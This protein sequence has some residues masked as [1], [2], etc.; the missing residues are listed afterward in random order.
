[1]NS[2]VKRSSSPM[3]RFK[4]QF[5]N[6]GSS[7]KLSKPREG[8]AMA[9]W[10][11]YLSSE[12][13]SPSTSYSWKQK[14]LE[15]QPSSGNSQKST[16]LDLVVQ[17]SKVADGLLNRMY[18]LN[19][20]LENPDVVSH[21]FSDP[22]WKAGILPN[23][24][25]ICTLVSKK[26][27]EH[28]SKLQLERVDKVA[29]DSISQN[30]EV[31]LQ[32]LEPWVMFLIDLMEFREQSLRLILDLSST[33]ITLLPHQNSLIL[34][35][36]MDLF[37]SFARVNLFSNKIPRK[38]FIQVYNLLHGLS[39]GGRDFEYYNRVVQ[40]INSYDPPIK[41]LQEDL[42]FV[43]P[44]IGE[45]LE[46][47]GPS[48]FL[49]TDTKKLRNEGFLSPFHP[50]YPDILTNSAHP[51][52]AQDLANVTSYREWVLLGY[53]VC[54]DELLR[55]T[56]IDI[57]M[58]ALKESMVLT[59]YRDEYLLLH[60]EYQLHVLPRILESKR[61]AKSGRTKQKEADLE[62]NVAKQVEKMICEVHEE[63]VISCNAIH[64]ERRVLLKQEIGRMVLFFADQPSLLAP[65]IQMVFSAL[66]FAQSEIIWFFQHLSASALGSKGTRLMPA[67]IDAA[68]PTIGFLLH[69]MDRL[70]SLVRKY[71]SAIRGY[72]LS[73]LSSCAGRMRFLLG[74]PGMVA[75]DLDAPLK[76]LFQQV[77]LCLDN[78]RKPQGDNISSLECDLSDL[79]RHWISILMIVTS[80]RSSINIRHLEKATASTGKEGLLSEGNFAYNWSRCV[81]EL[82]SQ[83]LKYG[84]LAKLYFY[85][86]HL[87]LVFKNTMFGP[88]GHPQH[89]VAWLGVAANF[90]CCASSTAPE[91]V[92]KIGRDSVSYVESLIESIMGGL[93]GLINILDAE[94]GFGSLDSQLSPEQVGIQIM[95]ETKTSISSSRSGK[96]FSGFLVPGLE[97]YPGNGK[98]LKTLEAAMQRLTDLCSVLNDMEPVC[99]LNHVFVLRE[100]MRD[101][102]LGNFRK[103][104]HSILKKDNGLQRPSV[105]ESLLRRHISI[106]HLAEQHISM[107]LTTGIREALLSEAYL[108][109]V[110]FLQTFEK[111]T[112]SQA[113]SAIEI[114]SNWYIDQIVKDVSGADVVFSPRHNCF[115]S[116][117]RTGGNSAENFT[118]T[119]ELKALFRIFGRYGFDKLDRAMREHMAALLN[120]IESTLLSNSEVL[121]AFEKER[122]LRQIVELESVVGFF[123]QAGRTIAFHRI[124]A[125]SAGAVFRENAPLI[126]SLLSSLKDNL[127]DEIPD[128]DPAKRLRN[129][130]K[131]CG[132][133]G[134]LDAEWVTSIMLERGSFD[135]GSWI[136]L[137]RLC[138]SFVVSSIWNTTHYDVH[139]GGFNTNL[140][141]LARSI[142]A[143]IAASEFV[144]SEKSELLKQSLSNGHGIEMH[145]GILTRL[146]VIENIKSSMQVYV[147]YSAGLI[148][149]S[150]DG[151]RS[152]LV[153]KLQFLD[154]LCRISPYLPRSTLELHVPYTLLRSLTG[155]QYTKSPSLAPLDIMPPSP[156]QSPRIS[157]AHSSPRPR[158]S[159]RDPSPS[160]SHDHSS[161]P[162]QGLRREATILY[163]VD[164]QQ[165]HGASKQGGA[166]NDAAGRRVKFIDNGANVGSSGGSGG[167]W[168]GRGA[169]PL[170]RFAVARSGLGP[171]K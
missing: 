111:P 130:A 4:A 127:P 14:I 78:V 115:K 35:A 6:D 54:P 128:K 132:N 105:I 3:V 71:V 21:T 41:G 99:V 104:F 58:V 148:L 159:Q 169:S 88:E 154:H 161:L 131:G 47:V 87:T 108:G 57:A 119:E 65:N 29:Y 28:T 157:L 141:C 26:F 138:A 45:I 109:P 53:L 18:R 1:M 156:G 142:S 136:L 137:P 163:D 149:T 160:G 102:I 77:V 133:R 49:S 100:Y 170:P 158:Q 116:S 106:I 112:A 8:D 73:F 120:C 5:S 86:N 68:D 34:H 19:R 59:M 62:Y 84:S 101:C 31:Y 80:S 95:N 107:D 24:P 164:G 27:P 91:E 126:A 55:V 94:G 79:R 103:R 9:R 96:G 90:V 25:R 70:C 162:L 56:S 50:R 60:E 61:M 64:H 82:E 146:V 93:E 72:A 40:F 98:S 46:A 81:D 36:F 97:S 44:R 66:A 171:S 151:N 92:N 7:A 139:I 166:G 13:S 63:V 37:C 33:V 124:L 135:N 52:R 145:P 76:G 165:A 114:V 67:D 147:K 11:E 15:T 39:R 16:N 144:R 150:S 2:P 20:Q 117:Q 122:N 153:P 152:H 48:I 83:L 168:G 22:F 143:I 51:M 38:M 69:G 43:S 32:N 121:E 113:V 75:L 10:H 118:S 74:T 129:V 140:Q 155:Q 12:R 85:K 17:M 123:I 42:N 125:E 30:A 167:S 110:L 134:E 23:H 89:C